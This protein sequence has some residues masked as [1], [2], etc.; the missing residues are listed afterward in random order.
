MTTCVGLCKDIPL[1]YCNLF[2]ASS[3]GELLTGQ[4]GLAFVVTFTSGCFFKADPS[5]GV[6]LTF[7]EGIWTYNELDFDPSFDLNGGSPG[8]N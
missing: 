3:L 1:T 8:A 4:A 6:S 2:Y 5:A 7:G